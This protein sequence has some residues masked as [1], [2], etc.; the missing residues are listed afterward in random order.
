MRRI[1]K[2]KGY[3]LQSEKVEI[4]T[5]YNAVFKE[6]NEKDKVIYQMVSTGLL[7]AG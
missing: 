7:L 2:A 5:T 1:D 6:D 3:A 4:K